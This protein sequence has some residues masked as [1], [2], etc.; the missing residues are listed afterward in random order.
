MIVGEVLPRG[1]VGAASVGGDPLAIASSIVARWFSKFDMVLLDT[2]S[3]EP[4]ALPR[5]IDFQRPS[6]A[7]RLAVARLSMC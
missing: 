7:M 4:S 6:N 2:T 3:V 5:P 1:A